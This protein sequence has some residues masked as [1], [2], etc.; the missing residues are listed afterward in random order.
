ME[1]MSVTVVAAFSTEIAELHPC[2]IAVIALTADASWTCW[3]SS[4]CTHAKL[5]A[6]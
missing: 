4:G 1:A 6:A 5:T 2:H 3:R